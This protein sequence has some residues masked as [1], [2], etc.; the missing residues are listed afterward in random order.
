MSYNRHGS[1]LYSYRPRCMLCLITHPGAYFL[2]NSHCQ[3]P[4][5]HFPAKH[6]LLPVCLSHATLLCGI[7]LLPLLYLV[8]NAN[9]TYTLQSCARTNEIVLLTLYLV[10]LLSTPKWARAAV[11]ELL[12]ECL[13]LPGPLQELVVA[14]CGELQCLP[15]QRMAQSKQ[16]HKS[17]LL[18]YP[19]AE[20][21]LRFSSMTETCALDRSSH[22]LLYCW[23]W[24]WAR[25]VLTLSVNSIS[26]L[27]L[28]FNVNHYF[29]Y[30][31]LFWRPS[32]TLR[33]SSSVDEGNKARLVR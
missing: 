31:L 17:E 20:G 29:I 3:M 10:L 5:V 27:T 30:V 28:N 14:E 11:W 6:K 25:R 22:P 15:W 9:S 4:K 12:F 13:N 2:S 23:H 8:M 16:I 18:Y 32:N 24:Q 33:V 19:C 7:R 21:L 26:C 1:P